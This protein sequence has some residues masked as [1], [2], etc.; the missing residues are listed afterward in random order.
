MSTDDHHTQNLYRYLLD[1]IPFVE[2]ELDYSILEKHIPH[3]DELDRLGNSAVSV[4]DLF[5]KTHVYTSPSYRN[6]LGL[7]I[8]NN[9]TPEG[10][11]LLMH[12]EDRK[13][14]IEAGYHFMK[15]SLSMDVRELRNYSMIHDY[16]IRNVS[17]S[18]ENEET[19][20]RMTEQQSL[21]ETDNRGNIWLS[22]SIVNIAS[23]QSPDQ[24]I[25]S[26]LVNKKTDQ[27]IEYKSQHNNTVSGLTNRENEILNLI[28]KGKS[29]KQIADQLFISVNT[30]NTHRQNIISKLKVNST[31]EAIGLM[32][33]H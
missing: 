22:L 24:P 30:V 10:F 18:G 20:I 32:S 21:L 26:I 28:S 14:T 6:R 27:I 2:G 7:K 19:W 29:S 8:E 15:M 25:R 17:S 23:N 13:N 16:R 5:K 4:F 3:L 9:D 11:E 33:K 1:S 31:T 12:P